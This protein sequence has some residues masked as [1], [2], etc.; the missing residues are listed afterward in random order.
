MGRP[1]A[2]ALAAAREPSLNDAGLKELAALK[3]L[4]T[5]NLSH[6]NVTD[7]GLKEL[8]ALKNLTTLNL[9]GTM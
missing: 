3:N 5:L 4:T 8:A 6:T 2:V 1:H 7:A 9:S